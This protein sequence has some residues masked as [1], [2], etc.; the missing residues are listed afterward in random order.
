MIRRSKSIQACFVLTFISVLLA[1][2]CPVIAQEAVDPGKAEQNKK[3]DP[4]STTASEIQQRLVDSQAELSTLI[5]AIKEEKLPLDAELRELE[6]Q[7]KQARKEYESLSRQSANRVREAANLEAQ[8]EQRIDSAS[9]VSNRMDEFIREF[10]AGLH[11]AELQRYEQPLEAAK[12]SMENRDL[13]SRDRFTVQRDVIEASLTRLEEAMGGASYTGSAIDSTGIL[14]K[15]GASVPGTFIQFGPVVVF[16]D[17]TG[18]LQGT[19]EQ[20]RGT[21]YPEVVPFHNP[22]HAAAVKTLVAQSKGTLPLDTTLGEA[23]VIEQIDE[24][25]L[26]D[27]LRAGGPV[28]IP[29]LILAGATALV[30]LYKF[31]MISL[32]TSPSRRKLAE[33]LDAVAENKIDKAKRVAKSMR[34]PSGKMLQAGAEHLGGPRELIEEVMY[35]KVLMA[36]LKVQRLL[37]FI[38]ICAAAAPLLGLLGTVSGI[39]NTFEMMQVSGASDMQNVSGGISEALITTKFG[40]I[41]AIPAL[42]LHVFLSRMA[43]GVVDKMEK[44]GVALINQVMKTPPADGDRLL[45]KATP[46]PSPDTPPVDPKPKPSVKPEKEKAVKVQATDESDETQIIPAEEL[47]Q[48]PA[49]VESS[50]GGDRSNA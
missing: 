50:V 49:L 46:T 30:G 10:E 12:L 21:L 13:A 9:F 15:Q 29:I 25:T 20:K 23:K 39:I 47:E 24:A 3:V 14:G 17:N 32:T 31:L 41:V 27:E 48:E 22:E 4:L 8:I 37:P 43:R 42:I 7:L 35:E 1:F 2:A 6:E 45:A 11:I 34:G 26:E 44:S 33:L 16:S 40:L 19:I 38:A 5:D 18:Q 36:K 28:M